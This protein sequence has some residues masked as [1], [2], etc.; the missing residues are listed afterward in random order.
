MQNKKKQEQQHVV[1][2][3]MKLIDFVQI[4]TWVKNV[5]PILDHSRFIHLFIHE[6]VLIPA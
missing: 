6:R 5:W 4:K 3:H 1:K 2:I